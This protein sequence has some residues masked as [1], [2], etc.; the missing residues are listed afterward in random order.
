M[1]TFLDLDEFT[2]KSRRRE[3]ED[4][5][6][7][8]L[9]A[10]VFLFCALLFAFVYSP[11]GF[12]W[13]FAFVQKFPSLSVGGLVALTPLLALFLI[14]SRK[15]IERFR[16]A[17]IWR[18]SGFVKPV[19][20]VDWRITLSALWVF[21][22]LVCVG[23]WGTVSG[24]LAPESDLRFMIGGIG[25]AAGI[26]YLGMGYILNFKRYMV[27]GSIGGILSMLI[28]VAPFSYSTSWAALGII[29]S[30]VLL[31]SG[32]VGLRDALRSSKESAND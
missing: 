4:G 11:S 16:R 20:K 3:F 25:I 26:M 10:I 12:W 21:V 9:N 6:V 29:W 19:H 18:E 28:L 2:R 1:N 32:F 7:D 5:L 17:R 13:Y 30:I 31:L 15:G 8:L 22:C 24:W 23:F 27:V 14:F